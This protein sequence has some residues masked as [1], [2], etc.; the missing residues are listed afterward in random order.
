M[1][2][3]LAENSIA[4]AASAIKSP[5]RASNDVH[6]FQDAVG[7]GVREDLDATFGRARARAHAVGG[8]RKAP[9]LNGTDCAVNSSSVLPTEAISQECVYTTPGI[10]S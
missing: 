8:E 10:A 7:L 6:A 9:F 3:A 4:T 2:S 1:S 5:A